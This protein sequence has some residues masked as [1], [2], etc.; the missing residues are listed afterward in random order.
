MSHLESMG[1]AVQFIENHLQEGIKVADIAGAVSYSLF[2]FCRV[3]NQ[4]TYHPP[5]DYL[6]R[7]RLSEAAW[8]LIHTEKCITDLAY[9]FQFGSP[10]AFSRA[11]KRLFGQL[12]S[13]LR[14]EGLR[15]PRVLMT[16]LTPTHLAF[17][18]RPDFRRPVMVQKPALTLMGLMTVL[19]PGQESIVPQLWQSVLQSV[20]GSTPKECYGVVHYPDFWTEKGKWYLAAVPVSSDDP[21]VPPLVTQSLPAHSYAVFNHYGSPADRQ[22]LSD[23]IYQTW[24]PQSGYRLDQPMEIELVKGFPGTVGFEIYIPIV[25]D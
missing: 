24:L 10:E 18:N 13:R 6:I 25:P 16:P 5:Y 11:F 4:T 9:D 14:Q 2:H 15:D 19:L 23:Y 3:F 7:R 17:R 21:A 1:A 22:L 20:P 12:P 8:Q